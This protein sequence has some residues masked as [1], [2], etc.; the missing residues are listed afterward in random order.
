MN[1][2]LVMESISKSV[3]SALIAY[4]THYG[5]T[6]FYSKVCVPDGIIG[7]LQGLVSTGSPVCQAGMTI[8]TNT[9]VSYS[10][11]IIMGIT[12]VIVDVVTPGVTKAE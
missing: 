11:M 7:Y 5:F 1:I 6:K 9:Q 8:M 10:S 2:L 12:R 3:L 4:S